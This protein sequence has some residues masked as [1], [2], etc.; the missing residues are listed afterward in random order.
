MFDGLMMQGNVMPDNFLRDAE[1]Y[2]LGETGYNI[3]L[4]Q[5]PIKDHYLEGLIAAAGVHVDPVVQGN[6][7]IDSFVEAPEK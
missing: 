2:V 1:L 4:S 6:G 7:Q 5:K 3:K